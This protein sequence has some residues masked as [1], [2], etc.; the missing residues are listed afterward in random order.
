MAALLT[1]LI[2]QGCAPQGEERSQDTIEL[3]NDSAT[4]SYEARSEMQKTPTD[5]ERKNEER[6]Q[7]IVKAKGDSET[8]EPE[9]YSGKEDVSRTDDVGDIRFVLVVSSQACKCTLKRCR[10]GKQY[11]EEVL[12]K[13]GLASNLSVLDQANEEEKTVQL[14][15]KYGIRFIPCLLVLDN[16]GEVRHR[17]DG[18]ID[19]AGFEEFLSQL[20]SAE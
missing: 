12:E 5:Q 6:N 7:D 14:V 17:H 13:V 1:S 18:S 2:L 9:V 11:L 10:E 3:K 15:K 16:D 4:V 20:G 19:R 8:A